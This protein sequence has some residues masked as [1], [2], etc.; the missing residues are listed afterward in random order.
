MTEI[1]AP[2]YDIASTRPSAR[3][4]LIDSEHLL[5]SSVPGLEYMNRAPQLTTPMGRYIGSSTRNYYNVSDINGQSL[6]HSTGIVNYGIQGPATPGFVSGNMMERDSPY[7]LQK[8]K[9]DDTIPAG[10]QFSP[11]TTRDIIP[12]V[13]TPYPFMRVGAFGDYHLLSNGWNDFGPGPTFR[14]QNDVQGPMFE[15]RYIDYTWL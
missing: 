14:M 4:P 1:A 6:V 12:A 13:F 2:S 9:T 5:W 11:E 10:S 15:N 7:S 3:K 8:V